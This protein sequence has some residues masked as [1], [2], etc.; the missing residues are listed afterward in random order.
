MKIKFNKK[1]FDY[2]S[3]NGSIVKMSDGQEYYKFPQYWLSSTDEKYVLEIQY[4]EDLFCE[5]Q[6]L[7]KRLKNGSE[8]NS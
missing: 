4:S 6:T 7:K 5:I 8:N 2:L 1:V 3:N